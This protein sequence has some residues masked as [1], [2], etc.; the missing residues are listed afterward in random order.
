MR[1][2]DATKTYLIQSQ[3]LP[4]KM[5]GPLEVH[6]NVCTSKLF[7]DVT[8]ATGWTESQSQLSEI[9]LLHF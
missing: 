5:L 1:K 8:E 7:R 3:A 2:Y 4:Y 6:T 9:R